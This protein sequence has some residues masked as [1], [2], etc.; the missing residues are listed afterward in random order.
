MSLPWLP[1]ERST[2]GESL[3]LEQNENGIGEVL[4]PGAVFREKP[5]EESAA[6]RDTVRIE[7]KNKTGRFCHEVYSCCHHDQ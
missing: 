6:S 7:K 2:A 3:F 5:L 4:I 1:D